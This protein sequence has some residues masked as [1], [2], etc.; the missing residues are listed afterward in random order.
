LDWAEGEEK[1]IP[2]I[3][4]ANDTRPGGDWEAGTYQKIKK[5]SF[6]FCFF[7]NSGIHSI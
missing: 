6:C 7:W 3:I 1:P 2:V 4:A 5:N